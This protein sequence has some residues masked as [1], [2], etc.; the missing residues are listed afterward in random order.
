[1]Y[2]LGVTDGRKLDMGGHVRVGEL[3]IWAEQVGEGSDVLLIAGLGDTVESW[4][5]Q[6]DGL[7]D[8]YRLIAF[9]NRGA[10][11]TAM[12]ERPASVE[13]MADDAAGVLR[14]LEIPSAHVAGFSGGSIISQE[15]ALR[16]PKR[17]QP[18]PAEHLGGAGPLSS[19]VGPLRPRVGRGRAERAGV[20]RVVFPSRRRLLARGR[21]SRLRSPALSRTKRLGHAYDAAPSARSGSVRLRESRVARSRCSSRAQLR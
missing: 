20:P 12:P 13:A 5:F 16:H 1:M 17:A 21:G 2:G 18:R 4:Q 8:R 9:D 19:V 14:A 11:R 15:L 6:L 3:D 7:A 10:G